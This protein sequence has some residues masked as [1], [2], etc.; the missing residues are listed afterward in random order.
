VRE[1]RD[2]HLHDIVYAERG[3]LIALPVQLPQPHENMR[4]IGSAN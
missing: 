2:G 1:G 4:I 3:A